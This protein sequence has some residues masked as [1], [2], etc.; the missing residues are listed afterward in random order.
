[1][2][3]FTLDSYGVQELGSSPSTDIGDL[4]RAR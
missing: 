3:L 2:I 4:Y 1:M